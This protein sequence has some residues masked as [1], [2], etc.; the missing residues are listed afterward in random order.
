MCNCIEEMNKELEKQNMNTKLELA[1][2]MKG[3]IKKVLICVVKL[4]DKIKKKPI[5]L[6]ATYC[7]FCGQK[8]ED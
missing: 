6:F 5:K 4:D 7:P 1:F 2:G 8:Y 3:V